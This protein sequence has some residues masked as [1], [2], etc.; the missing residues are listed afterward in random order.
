[1]FRKL[2][3]WPPRYF[4]VVAI[5]IREVSTESTPECFLWF[6][7]DAS[8]SRFGTSYNFNNVVF[9]SSIVG[10]RHATKSATKAS[11]SSG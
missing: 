11:L 5:K 2:K 3:H 1:M 6:F 7:H 8:T 9:A 4:P 10:K